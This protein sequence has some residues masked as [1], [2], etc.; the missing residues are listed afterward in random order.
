VV[1][2]IDRFAFMKSTQSGWEIY[3]MSKTAKPHLRD[4]RS[5][6]R[7]K[8]G[9]DMELVGQAGKLSAGEQEIFDTADRGVCDDLQ[10]QCAGQSLPGRRGG[11]RGCA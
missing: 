7:D 6:V 4:Q 10:L 2:D 5:Y 8:D 1:S 3:V 9:G 11:A